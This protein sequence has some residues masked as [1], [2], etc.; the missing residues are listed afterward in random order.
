MTSPQASPT[1]SELVATAAKALETGGY[2][3]IDKGFPEW[4][5][6][7]SRLF[8]D[9]Y[10][11]VGLA[12]FPTCRELLL[13]WPDLQG[14]LVDLISQKVGQAESKAWDGYLVLLTP[15]VAPS[16]ELEIEEVRY[17]TTRLRKLVATGNDLS[18]ASDVERFLRPLLPL[19]IGKR[20]MTQGTALDMLPALLQVLEVD[21]AT[22]RVLVD[23]FAKQAPL[24][25][26]LHRRETTP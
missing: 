9:E 14:S 6:S 4:N 18:A 8:E 1:Q 24:M 13:S 7:S 26:A 20:T 12:I 11:V 3:P 25:E 10:N 17:D 19:R 2:R 15:G 22:T 16:D 23:A 5:T 21:Q